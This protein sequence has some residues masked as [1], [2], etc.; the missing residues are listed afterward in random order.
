M[1]SGV[2]QGSVFGALLFSNYVNELPNVC[3]N[4]STACYFDDTKPLLS[5]TVNDSARVIESVNTDLQRIR[6]WYFDNCLMLNQDNTSNMIS[7]T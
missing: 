7:D 6:N 3:K 2:P 1:L 5:F 4:C